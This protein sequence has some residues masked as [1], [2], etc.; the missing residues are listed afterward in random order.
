MILKTASQALGYIF[1]AV[2]A[3]LA[4]TI[5]SKTLGPQAYSQQAKPAKPAAANSQIEAVAPAAP[6]APANAPA[7]PAPAT[8][9]EQPAAPATIPS[10]NAAAQPAPVSALEGIIED[11]SYSAEGKRDPF[12]PVQNTSGTEPI[13]GPT[14]PL[15]RF[16]LDQLKLAGIIWDVKSPKAMVLD[17][18]GKGHVVKVN[19]RVGKNNGYI[20]RIR[21]GEIVI[22]ESYT[23]QDGAVSYQTKVMKLTQDQ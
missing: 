8:P 22:V 11:Y 7:Q 16:D 23:A 12:M 3:V 17:P 9:I 20:A 6:A 10:Q 14:F 13:I 18:T 1:V 5:V 19:E 2:M 4:A 21:E 15:Q